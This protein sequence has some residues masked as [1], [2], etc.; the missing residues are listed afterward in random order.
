MP[1]FVYEPVLDENES[2][3]AP[4][5][6]A[7]CYFETLQWSNEAPLVVCPACG[8]TIRRSVTSFAL[9]APANPDPLRGIGKN[10]GEGLSA[11]GESLPSAEKSEGRSLI[12]SSASQTP[13][14]R[15]ARL[16]YRHV[17]SGN[18]RH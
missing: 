5:D 4:Q 3:A 16:A 1:I 12:S 2:D 15:A 7:C 8:K 11:A 18:C 14:G 17:C 13:A 6:R 9:A 10:I